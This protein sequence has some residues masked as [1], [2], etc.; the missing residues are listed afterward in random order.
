LGQIRVPRREPLARL[1]TPISGAVDCGIVT[2][3]SGVISSP[4]PRPAEDRPEPSDALRLY[5]ELAREL[6]A[7]LGVALLSLPPERRSIQ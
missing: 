4:E 3:L 6:A 5:I 1:D 7:R 2:T